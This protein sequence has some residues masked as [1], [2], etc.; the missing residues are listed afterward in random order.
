MVIVRFR[1]VI[2]V[3]VRFMRSVRVMVIVSVMG[4]DHCSGLCYCYC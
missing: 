1:V 4:Y 2:M 3:I